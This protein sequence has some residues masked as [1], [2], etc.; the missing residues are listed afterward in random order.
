MATYQTVTIA[1]AG[2]LSAEVPIEGLT[3]AGII[4]P[5]AWTTA[6]LTFQ[7][8]I[9]SGTVENLYDEYGTEVTVTA[10]ASRYIAVSPEQFVG[11]KY[12]KV[13]SGTSGTPVAQGAE[14]SLTLVLI[15]ALG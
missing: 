7:G 13:R 9:V 14:R 8:G 15:P 10:A 2:S 3:L 4:M 1:S 5:A 6:N 12:L 11:I